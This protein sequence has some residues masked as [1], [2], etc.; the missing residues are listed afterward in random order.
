MGGGYIFSGI[1]GLIFGSYGMDLDSGY[2]GK[3]V[4]L[5]A[6]MRDRPLRNDGMKDEQ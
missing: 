6:R 1:G 3:R 2:K 4:D 5:P